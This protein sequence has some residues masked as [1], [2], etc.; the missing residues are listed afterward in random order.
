MLIAFGHCR[1]KERKKKTKHRVEAQKCI[2]RK[3][4]LHFAHESLHFFPLPLPLVVFSGRRF[5]C[6][7]LHSL[8]ISV[9][10][11]LRYFIVEMQHLVHKMPIDGDLMRFCVK[12]RK[13]PPHGIEIKGTPHQRQI[14]THRRYYIKIGHFLRSR[15]S[16]VCLLFAISLVRTA[17]SLIRVAFCRHIVRVVLRFSVRS[18]FLFRIG[19]GSS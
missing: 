14:T 10:L 7:R 8:S 6:S 2:R 17:F 4:A 18:A 13:P 16:I 12:R 11:L 19:Y 9:W 5:S 3:N 15:C 1:H